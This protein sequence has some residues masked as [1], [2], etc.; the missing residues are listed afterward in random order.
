VIHWKPSARCGDSRWK[1]GDL[2]DRDAAKTSTLCFSGLGGAGPGGW[3][4]ERGGGL[5]AVRGL[6]LAGLEGRSVLWG[7]GV[8]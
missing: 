5:G 7:G 8:C 6:R 1:R 2:R 4:R 3:Q